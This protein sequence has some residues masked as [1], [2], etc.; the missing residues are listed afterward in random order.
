MS[1]D[2]H[3]TLITCTCTCRCIELEY[4][5]LAKYDFHNDTVN[6][7]INIDLKPTTILRPYQGKSLRKMFG[8]GRARSGVIVLPCAVAVEQ[9]W[10]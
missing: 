4:P 6:P 3:V 9:W 8:N 10:S 5:L 2:Y 1:C 7:D